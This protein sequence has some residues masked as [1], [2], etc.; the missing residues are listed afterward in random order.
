MSQQAY[1]IYSVPESILTI[2]SNFFPNAK[3]KAQESILIEQYSKLN[4]EKKNSIHLFER[5]ESK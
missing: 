1:L 4:N 3:Y 5:T 2:V